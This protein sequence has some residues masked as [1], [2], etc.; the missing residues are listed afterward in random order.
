MSILTWMNEITTDFFLICIFVYMIYVKETF[1]LMVDF[2][3][4]LSKWKL[5]NSVTIGQSYTNI[6]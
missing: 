4:T 3:K 2:N 5:L 6:I 1:N